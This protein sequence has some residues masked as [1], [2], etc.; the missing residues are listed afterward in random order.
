MKQDIHNS[1]IQ[2]QYPLIKPDALIK[3][4]PISARESHTILQARTVVS[5]IMRAKENKL[6]VVVGPC[7]IHDPKAAL[8]Y[9]GLLHAAA[10]RFNEEL[11]LVMRV[12]FEKPR[13]TVGWKG[14]ISDPFLNNTFD[15]NEGLRIARKLLLDLNNMGVP[16]ATEFL[17]T[18]IPPYLSDLIAWTAIGARTSA[19]QVHR[20]LASGLSMPVGFKNNTDGNIK[21]AIDAVKVASFPHHFIS[22]SHDGSP[23]IVH[24]SGN[25]ACHIILRG[26]QH[27]PNYE[28]TFVQSA[29]HQLELAGLIPRIMVDCSHGNSMKNYLLQQQGID[30]VAKQIESGAPVIGGIMLESNL[31]AGKQTLNS[32]KSLTYGQ[33][34]TDECLSWDETLPLLEKLACAVKSRK[35]LKI[36]LSTFC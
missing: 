31:I 17:D 36:E 3:E 19:S 25:S 34:I 9:A 33:S 23:S 22:M 13:T 35:N 26:S 12:Y 1:G 11:C 2:S 7:S 5:N 29:A 28:P 4:L 24:T 27:G 20:E 15:M 18:M 30:S 21:I 8:E 14:L 10:E 6:L 32:E 16:A